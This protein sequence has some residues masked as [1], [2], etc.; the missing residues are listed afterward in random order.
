MLFG[1]TLRFG[2]CNAPP[3][4]RP[5]AADAENLSLCVFRVCIVRSRW[6][7][8]QKWAANKWVW[9]APVHVSFGAVVLVIRLFPNRTTMWMWLRRGENVS[10]VLTMR[11]DGATPEPWPRLS[12][13]QAD[14]RAELVGVNVPFLRSAHPIARC[15]SSLSGLLLAC[16]K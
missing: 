4:S 6:G 1:D 5:P 12:P 7:T 2:K 3:P 13:S 11:K 8:G 16:R 9:S 14:T 10:C 15:M